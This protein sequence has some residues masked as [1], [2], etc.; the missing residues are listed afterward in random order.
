MNRRVHFT[1]SEA[2]YNLGDAECLRVFTFRLRG[3]LPSLH[4]MLPTCEFHFGVGFG[5]GYLIPLPKPPELNDCAQ[6]KKFI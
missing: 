4:V 1:S 3:S 2:K 6:L 5:T